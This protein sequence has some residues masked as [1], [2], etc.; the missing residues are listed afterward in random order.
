MNGLIGRKL[1]MTRVFEEDGRSTP[2]TVIE[3]GPCAV[4]QVRAD[5]AAAASSP[6]PAVP[7]VAPTAL[8]TPRER[9]VLELLARRL[10]NKQIATALDVGQA[11]IKWHLKNLYAKLKAGT[12]E[13]AL[14]RA[15][16]LGILVGV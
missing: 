8:L 15:R 13:H 16:M 1:G 9:A 11:T 12:R 7:A 5:E 3:A 4:V 10:S 14:Q 2:V 6:A